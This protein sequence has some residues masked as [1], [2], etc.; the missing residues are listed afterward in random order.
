M[1]LP[2]GQRIVLFD[3]MPA[4]V[5]ADPSL[6]ETCARDGQSLYVITMPESNRAQWTPDGFQLNANP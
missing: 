6:A 1:T 2:G 3:L 4:S 5:L